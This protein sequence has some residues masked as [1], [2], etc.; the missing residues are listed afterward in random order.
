LFPNK[1]FDYFFI[2]DYYDQQ[3]KS[4]LYFSRI[5]GLFAGVAVFIACLG[6]LG[7]TLF[8]ANAR[9]KELSIRKVLGASVSSLMALLS[10]GYFKLILLSAFVSVPV[11]YWSATKWLESYPVKIE[12]SVWYFIF[13]LTTVIVMAILASG[14]Q[15]FKA[16]NSN[17]VDNLK[18]E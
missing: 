2:D 18:H 16:A 10:K 3:F 9:I 11:I 15:T 17:P 1:P 13:P 5:F 4:E 14:V 12:V 8:E 7:M 6:I